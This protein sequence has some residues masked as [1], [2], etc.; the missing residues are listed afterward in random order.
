VATLDLPPDIRMRQSGATRFVFNH[1]PEPVEFEGRMIP[2]AG[3]DWQQQ[4]GL[5]H[6]VGKGRRDGAVETA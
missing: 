1:G 6:D 4:G 2:P 5:P 3:V